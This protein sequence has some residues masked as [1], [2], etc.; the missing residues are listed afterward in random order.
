V[1]S[2]ST[3]DSIDMTFDIPLGD[4]DPK[5]QGVPSQKHCG[6]TGGDAKQVA[7]TLAPDEYIVR[8]SGHYGNTVDF[9]YI[10]TSKPQ[11]RNFGVE[12][13][14]APG[15]FDYIAP[16]G[17]AITALVIKACTFVDAVGVVLQPRPR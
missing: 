5:D 13:S 1:Q 12:N 9:L 6:G 11:F 3:I 17:T 14:D 7:L 15:T 16:E 4:L 8:V 10:Q 2:G